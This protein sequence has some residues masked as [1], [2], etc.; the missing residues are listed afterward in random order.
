MSTTQPIRDLAQVRTISNHYLNLGNHRN[1]RLVVFCLNS[2]LRIGD[3]LSI[4]WGDVY[5]FKRKRPYETLTIKEQ[6]TDK[7]KTIA[8][9]KKIVKVL[10]H[11]A[12]H[13]KPHEFL[14]ANANTG[15]AISRAQAYRII[16]EAGNAASISQHISP[17]SLRKT[18]GY[19]AWRSGVSPAVIMEIYNH[20]SL[21]HTRRYLGVIQ[22]DLN[23]VYLG[24]IL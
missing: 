19:H 2:A 1:H 14:F 4:R 9:N 16:R 3:V 7:T 21:N 23:A 17:H 20:S 5:D 12:V 11:S 13:A 6:K 24:I 22:D 15:K 8:L 18:F 10:K